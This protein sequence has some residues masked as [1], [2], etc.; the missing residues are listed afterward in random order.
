MFA[1]FDELFDCPATCDFSLELAHLIEPCDL[2]GLDEPFN[3]EEIWNGIKLSRKAPGPDGLTAEFVRA[4]WGT[5]RINFLDIFQQLY[6]LRSRGFSKLNQALLTLLPKHADA[7]A[8]RNYRPICLIHLMAI[9]FTKVISL[10]L[11]P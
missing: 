3:P 5:N 6:E 11:A 2:A 7:S 4:C 10:R 1:H 8:L 9:I